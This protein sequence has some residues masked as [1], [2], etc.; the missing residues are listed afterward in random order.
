MP[1]PKRDPVMS[2]DEERSVLAGWTRRR[3]IAL[4]LKAR[5]VL[6]CAKGGS[7][8]MSQS[9]LSRI[10]RA[11]GLK[12]HAVET[13][14]L[15]ADPSRRHRTRNRGSLVRQKGLTF[16]EKVASVVHI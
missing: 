5:I 14:K 15:S 4:T 1:S 13:W 7:I 2:S 10:W 9:A 11:F 8:G 3:K 16:A 6:C 12:P